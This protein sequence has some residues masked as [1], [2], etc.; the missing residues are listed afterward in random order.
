MFDYF[1]LYFDAYVFFFSIHSWIV[2]SLLLS[3]FTKR[4]RIHRFKQHNNKFFVSMWSYGQSAHTVW[5][6]YTYLSK[7]VLPRS[8]VS[9][10]NKRIAR[11]LAFDYF[12][13]KQFTLFLSFHYASI[14]KSPFTQQVP[15]QKL[16]R[17]IALESSN[18]GSCRFRIYH[19]RCT[20]SKDFAVYVLLFFSLH[21]FS[22]NF[23]WNQHY[24]VERN[25]TLDE[26]IKWIKNWRYIKWNNF[27]GFCS[28]CYCYH[29]FCL[30]L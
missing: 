26:F 10:R 18:I 20:E 5:N 17:N 13:S 24:D 7:V 11:V 14:M 16:K 23:N 21:I 25:F 22:G 19:N 4:R 15:L 30:T 2:S 28:D 6:I 29:C 1:S 8:H 27:K 9:I 3:F 12:V